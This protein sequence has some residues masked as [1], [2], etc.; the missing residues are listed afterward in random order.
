[1]KGVLIMTKLEEKEI[2]MKCINE[3]ANNLSVLKGIIPCIIT[4]SQE[5]AQLMKDAYK[6]VC[7]MTEFIDE[8]DGNLGY[9]SEEFDIDKIIKEYPKMS[10]LFKHAQ[11]DY[12]N[13]EL[14]FK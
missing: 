7:Q 8:C 13:D 10:E 6:V 5:D 3:F 9:L 14:P 1:M 4:Q 12:D 2:V 11:N